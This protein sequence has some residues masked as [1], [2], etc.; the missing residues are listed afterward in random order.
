MK[1]FKSDWHAAILVCDT[2]LVLYSILYGL[3]IQ[4]TSSSSSHG[5]WLELKSSLGSGTS[6][7]RLAEQI[8]WSVSAIL[9]DS[10]G[11]QH[12]RA[13]HGRR[14]QICV[15]NQVELKSFFLNVNAHVV[16]GIRSVSCLSDFPIDVNNVH[17]FLAF[18]SFIGVIFQSR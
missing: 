6:H 9:T 13:S 12:D 4:D 18:C 14:S 15:R 1:Y 7:A 3:C 8:G 10:S 16:T 5:C 11:L 2:G 17:Y